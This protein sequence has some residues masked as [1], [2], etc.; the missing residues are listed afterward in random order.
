MRRVLLID[1]D[2]AIRE[3]AVVALEV[4]GG[5]EVLSAGSGQEGVR[6]AVRERPDVVLLD[7]MMPGMDGPTA[8]SLLR[9]DSRTQDIPVIFL[10]AKLQAAE[11]RR[12]DGLHVAGVL[13]KPF[14]PMRLPGQI[15]DLLGWT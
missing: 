7:V 12:W 2:D 3:V 10:T 6:L 5:W 15:S 13:A 14:D 11:Q 1:D 8:L 9:A 4:V